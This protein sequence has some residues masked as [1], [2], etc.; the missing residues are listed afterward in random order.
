MIAEVLHAEAAWDAVL[1][2]EWCCRAVLDKL[3]P[4]FRHPFAVGPTFFCGEHAIHGQMSAQKKSLVP[5]Y[6]C[7]LEVLR[8][9]ALQSSPPRASFGFRAPS[10]G[11]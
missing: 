3:K 4:E 1:E 10:S 2:V 7:I 9:L 11:L 6:S 8:E 5:V